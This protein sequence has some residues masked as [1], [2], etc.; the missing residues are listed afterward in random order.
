MREREI[1]CVRVC[2]CVCA[3]A[4]LCV[5]VCVCVPPLR[6]VC[7]CVC[8]CVLIPF[9]LC[10]QSMAEYQMDAMN[11]NFCVLWGL[12]SST[13]IT[14]RDKSDGRVRAYIGQREYNPTNLTESLL[15]GCLLKRLFIFM[16]WR[17]REKERERE[18]GE[19]EREACLWYGERQRQS[20]LVLTLGLHLPYQANLY[21]STKIR[22]DATTRERERERW[23][24]RERGRETDRQ[25]DRQREAC[26]YGRTETESLL[27]L[28]LGLHLLY[29]AN[30]YL[31]T[32][33][34]SD[35]TT[36]LSLAFFLLLFCAC[37]QENNAQT[38]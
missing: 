21:L 20:L 36:R 1:V 30:L 18:G 24:E 28:T 31:S 9:G 33:I 37:G 2:V 3:R 27:V 5:Y 15:C 4:P 22:S 32:R 29:Q 14:D 38:R 26:L 10:F 34:R 7:V 8:V 35:A 12:L 23:R 17:E 6:C 25:T 13:C 11:K 19:R 16:I